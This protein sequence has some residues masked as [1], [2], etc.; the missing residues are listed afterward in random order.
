MAT[1]A[2]TRS[3]VKK[4]QTYTDS[5]SS[6]GQDET[7]AESAGVADT[8]GRPVGGVDL[9]NPN[10]NIDK[11]KE[12]NLHTIVDLINGADNDNEIFDQQY[13][14]ADELVRDYGEKLTAVVQ[15]PHESRVD[16]FNGENMP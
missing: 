1:H 12:D 13:R 7:Q 15:C 2:R 16:C 11:A 4:T 8:Q 3:Q 14:N 6:A 5:G 9:P 10:E